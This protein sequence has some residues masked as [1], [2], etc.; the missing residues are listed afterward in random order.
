MDGSGKA[1]TKL[2]FGKQ[3]AAMREAF[4]PALVVSLINLPLSCGIAM[5]SGAPPLAGLI[6]AIVSGFLMAVLGGSYVT[7]PGP[8]A[9]LAPALLAGTLLL[10]HSDRAVGYPLLLVAVA[11]TGLILIMIGRHRLARYAAIFPANVVEGMLAGIGMMII[12]RQF[13]LI[14]GHAFH[15]TSFWGMLI[16]TPRQLLQADPKVFSI[17]LLCLATVFTLDAIQSA[18]KKI[19]PPQIAVVLLGFGLSLVLG[20]KARHCLDLPSNPL[21]GII[22]PN[23]RGV[24]EGRVWAELLKVVPIITIVKIIEALATAAAVDKMDPEGRKSDP[25]RLLRSLGITNLC[26][27][28]IGGLPVI[29]E[30][31]RSQAAIASGS[32]TP[33][34]SFLN[35]GFL[36][37]FLFLGG[38]LIR[39]LP[40]AA[41]AAVIIFTGWRLCHPTNWW[42]AAK[43]G[44]EQLLIFSVTAFVTVTEGLFEAILTGMATEVLVTWYI[45]HKY[46]KPDAMFFDTV[47][48]FLENPIT[49]TDFEEEA[50][51]FHLHLEH[52]PLTAFNLRYLDEALCM[53]PSRAKR[54][55]LHFRKMKTLLVDHTG[56]VGLQKFEAEVRKSGRTLLG[57][58]RAREVYFYQRSSHEYGIAVPKPPLMNPAD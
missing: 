45:V 26:S 18:R 21:A 2:E 32:R 4:F 23:V 16:E 54:I 7:I 20:L 3:V 15:S 49:R 14:T 12:V 34:T 40:L 22:L 39:R 55:K 27:S 36:L 44:R 28:L 5:A 11:I 13:P 58:Q 37:L 8:A 25:N 17:G 57:Y 30:A 48:S 41:L 42:H 33:W 24:F 46:V 50:L 9:G 38:P 47:R 52:G 53:A 56:V 51:T 29:P 19:M 1:H 10:G 6:A 35:A 31:G 43:I